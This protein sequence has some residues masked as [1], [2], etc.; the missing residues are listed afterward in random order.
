MNPL[1]DDNL[2]SLRD[3]RQKLRAGWSLRQDELDTLEAEWARLVEPEKHDRSENFGVC[4]LDG[5]ETGV[6]GPRWLFHLF[7][8]CHRSAH[9][10]FSTPTGLVM[11]QRR[12]PTKADWPNMWDMAV[13]GHVPVGDDGKPLAYLDAAW[14]EIEE[15]I[16]LAEKDRSGTLVGGELVEVCAAFFTLDMDEARNPP[17]YNAEVHQLYGATLT[18]EGLASLKPDPEELSGLYFCPAEEAWDMLAREPIAAGLRF[19]LPRYLDWLA[20]QTSDA[21]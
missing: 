11:I 4:Q 1:S 20:K 3:A 9:I 14:K 10:G 16:G 13:A 15:E 18:P 5:S 2:K 17:F 6:I 7:G 19:S 8:L 21:T 12:A